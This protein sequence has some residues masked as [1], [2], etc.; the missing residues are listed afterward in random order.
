MTF[1]SV[2]GK[3][4]TKDTVHRA[5]KSWNSV[6]LLGALPLAMS[7]LVN[8]RHRSV[9]YSDTPAGWGLALREVLHEAIDTLKP[10][11]DI[12]APLAKKWRSYIILNEQFVHGHSPDFVAKKLYVSRSS[13]F[14]EQKKAFHV[15]A[16]LLAQWEE[17]TQV[18]RAAPRLRPAVTTFAAPFLAPPRPNHHL[19]GREGVFDV[20]KERF[21]TGQNILCALQGLP[22]VGK[23]A[24]AIE[25]VHDPELLSYYPDGVLWAGLGTRPDVL[26]LLGGWAAALR[27]PIK[28]RMNPIELAWAIHAAISNRRMLFIIDDAWQSEAAW[29]FKVGG[30][31]CAYLLTTRLVNVA[32]DF[33]GE[34]TVHI[35][36]IGTSDGVAL[37][38]QVAPGAVEQEPEAART[39]V[40]AVGGLPLALILMGRHLRQQSHGSQL[41]RIRAALAQLNDTETRLLLARPV[42]P[43]EQRPGLPYDMPLS[44]HALIGI[45]DTALDK[46]TRQALR[47]LALFPPKPNSFSEA[48]A[49]AVAGVVASVVDTLVD[50]GLVE[51]VQEGR[52]TLHQTIADYAGLEAPTPEARRRLVDYWVR[53]L[54]AQ[55][56]TDEILDL[57]L[58]NLMA[59]LE[60][61]YQQGLK[62]ALI[63]L[64]L[65]LQPFLLKRGLLTMSE[66]HLS[67]ALELTPES[68]Y[69]N[70]YD[71]LMAREAVLHFQG[72][73]EAQKQDLESLDVLA[74]ILDDDRCR[75]QVTLRRSAYADA[76]GD[77]LASLQMS[78][79]TVELA[80]KIDAKQ[81]EASGHL[82]WGQVL[83]SQAEYESARHQFE[84]ALA[85]ARQIDLPDIEAE[86]L[87]ELSRVFLNCYQ[88]YAG[89][90]SY[91]EQALQINRRINDQM[92]EG[93]TLNSLGY[94]AVHRGVYAEASIYFGQ[95]LQ[96]SRTLGE[97]RAEARTLNNIGWVLVYHQNDHAQARTLFEQA[98]NIC[99]E[100]GDRQVEGMSLANLG[101][102]LQSLGDYSGAQTCFEQALQISREV[103]DRWNE[104]AAL[105]NLGEVARRLGD[106]AKARS[107]VTQALQIYREI[108]LPHEIS[109]VLAKLG[110]ISH[111]LGDEQAA[112]EYCCQ[113]EIT[114]EPRIRACAL[115][116]LGHALFGLGR[117]DEA[118]AAYEQAVGLRRELGQLSLAME[119]LA[120]SAQVALARGKKAQAK[121]QVKEILKY[122]DTDL[123]SCSE[124]PFWVYLT[125]CRVLHA[126][127]DVRTMA[128]VNTA[129]TLLQEQ[130]SKISPETARQ[131]FLNDV[132]S[133]RALIVLWKELTV[134]IT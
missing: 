131:V 2:P 60:I 39:L 8:A 87:R 90:L 83:F 92:A 51:V 126:S 15:L 111:Q 97:R 101:S 114:D 66:Q 20:I 3:V 48:V 125:C 40:K 26:A 44:L 46:V 5:L 91:L 34:N 13:Y 72:R 79:R 82:Q 35:Q 93:V 74:E 33:A 112:W 120:G 63:T 11:D 54:S 118:A 42:S 24:L 104:S 128:F 55:P 113:A 75:V 85:L 41:R 19:V 23:T 69:T 52:Y 99:R 71:L 100:I 65:I 37:L 127:K 49:L 10:E 108:S 30:D 117:L 4:I 130:A 94:L 1:P 134:N 122:L 98:L 124:D 116:N 133:H 58:N 119:S 32:D 16:D 81:V 95:A 77:H 102:S 6:Q 64:S 78:Q 103:G 22:G 132:P 121:R 80:R 86:S 88:D 29:A 7:Q 62:M 73:R 107:Y 129:R 53:F 21:L 84:Q 31:Q 56:I 89:A 36:E 67:R 106:F 28:E 12:P 50:Y 17:K 61:A 115:T 45:S 109:T 59:G 57:E 70:Q 9:G 105:D 76:T 110:L 27:V 38:A 96:I 25:L 43:L 14:K 123:L 18:K 68:D 47:D